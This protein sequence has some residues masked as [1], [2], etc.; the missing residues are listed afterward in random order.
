MSNRYNG[1]RNVQDLEKALADVKKRRAHSERKFDRR[2][3]QTQNFL[4]PISAVSNFVGGKGFWGGLYLVT[5]LA[6]RI[7]GKKKRRK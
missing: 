5:S 4:N 3:R 6:S 2:Y 7:F 1:I